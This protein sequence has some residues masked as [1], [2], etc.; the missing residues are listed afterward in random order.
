MK[1]F[2]RIFAFALAAMLLLAMPLSVSA[3]EA[4]A[5]KS[6][7]VSFS[8]PAVY[9]VDG[10]FEYSNKGLFS[11]ITYRHNNALAGDIAND[12]VFLYGSSEGDVV[13]ELTVTVKSGASVGDSCQITFTYET[14]DADGQMSTWKSQS[15]TVSVKEAENEVTTAAPADTSKPS[16][17]SDGADGKDTDA[18][19][20]DAPLPP[21][22]PTPPETTSPAVTDPPVDVRDTEGPGVDYTELIRQINIVK[23][24]D[25]N[26]YTVDSWDEM[27]KAYNTANSLTSGKDQAE[28]DNAAADLSRAIAALVKVDHTDLM[29]AVE[30]AKALGDTP[31]HGD[32]WEKLFDA[33]RRSEEVLSGRDQGDVDALTEEINGLINDIKSDSENLGGK[34]VEVVKEVEVLPEGDY[35]NIGM[36]AVWKWLFFISLAVNLILIVLIILFLRKRKKNQKDDTPL[37]DYDIGDDE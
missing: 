25:E 3:A 10:Y 14:S 20:T 9:G 17:T 6:V 12:R 37:V 23:S 15:Q 34:I 7:T 8:V 5:G 27:M 11:G 4:E 2:N 22:P 24:L 26:E 36:H 31:A 21:A 1:L 35:C 30:A 19:V 29:R 32:L 18:P 33:V 13:I 28:V 16:D